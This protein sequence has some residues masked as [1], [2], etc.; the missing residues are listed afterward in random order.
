MKI[1]RLNDIEII[2]TIEN[3]KQYIK[4]DIIYKKY[5]KSS[6]KEKLEFSDFDMYCVE[7]CRDIERLI[8]SYEKIAIGGK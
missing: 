5:K 1:S 7:H 4:D 6:E 3:L 2:Q 8:N